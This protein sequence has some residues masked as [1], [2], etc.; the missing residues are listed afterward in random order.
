VSDVISAII[1]L[2]GSEANDF[3]IDFLFL[4]IDNFISHLCHVHVRFLFVFAESL[5]GVA[6]R[7]V[8][9]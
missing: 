4:E 3:V 5:L 7:N 1:S 8:D 6:S 2:S 9:A